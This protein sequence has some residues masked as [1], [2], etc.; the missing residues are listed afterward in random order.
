M[1]QSGGPLTRAIPSSKAASA[2]EAI[3]VGSSDPLVRMTDN[4]L[5]RARSASSRSEVSMTLPS[6]PASSMSAVS[7]PLLK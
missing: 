7:S 4:P 3:L 5:P 1:E 6:A 2:R